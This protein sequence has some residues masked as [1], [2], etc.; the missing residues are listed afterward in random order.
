MN[1]S[2]SITD[3]FKS[4]KWGMNMLLGGVC[5]II[6]VIGPLVLGGWH[7]TCL[8][9]RGNESDPRKL[10]DFDFQFFAKYLERGLWPFL[11]SMVASMVLVPVLLVL[12]FIPLLLAGFPFEGSGRPLSVGFVPLIFMAMFGIYLIFLF[13]FNLILTPLVLRSTIL[14]TF[15]ASFDFGFIKDFISKT[16]LEMT[17]AMLFMLGVGLIVMILAVIT[18]YIGGIFAAPVAIFAWHHLQKQIY[19]I[20]LNRG[21]EA[22]AVSPKLCDLPPA[23][24]Q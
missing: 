11:V 14:Q 17:L 8:W 16:W 15:A 22:L 4:P 12:A 3:F 20:Y 1:Y 24:P 19:R 13:G 9:A 21:G 6:P 18:C 2:A 7:I 5:M 23:L 10:P